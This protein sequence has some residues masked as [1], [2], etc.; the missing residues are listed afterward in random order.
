MSVLHGELRF[1]LEG[2]FQ[3]SIVTADAQF[4]A[5]VCAVIFDGSIMDE[6]FCG[7]LF[8]GFIRRYQQ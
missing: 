5:D 4:L 6:K 1:V 2:K 7:D 3:Q 8:T